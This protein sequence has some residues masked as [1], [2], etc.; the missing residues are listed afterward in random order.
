MEMSAVAAVTISY[1]HCFGCDGGGG[2]NVS[3]GSG[4]GGYNCDCDCSDC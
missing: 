3:G 1:R 4:S 2:V